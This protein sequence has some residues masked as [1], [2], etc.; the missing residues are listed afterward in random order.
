MYRLGTV[1][2]QRLDKYAKDGTPPP[3]L[4][5][6]LY[7]PDAEASLRVSVPVMVAVVEDLLPPKKSA[8]AGAEGK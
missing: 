5:S 7:Y 8:T 2:Q 4:H 3:S 1:D 6:P